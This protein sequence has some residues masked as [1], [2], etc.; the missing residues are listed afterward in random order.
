MKIYTKTGDK[1][2]TSLYGGK[3]VSKSTLRIEAYGTVD[4][5]NSVIGICRSMWPPEELDGILEELQ[6]VLFVLGADLATP[7]DATTKIHR[8]STEDVEQLEKYID[9]IEPQLEPLKSFILPGGT[10]VASYLHFTRTICR[11]AERVVVQLS[12]EESIGD[13]PVIFINRLSDFLFV[14]ARWAN[15]LEGREEIKWSPK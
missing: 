1:G 14:L 13:I 11:R 2:E 4:E 6:E 15:K 3:R 5:L 10:G 9:S 8:I 7:L 12:K